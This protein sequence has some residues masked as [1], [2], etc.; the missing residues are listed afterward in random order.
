M[1]APLLP[2]PCNVL[3]RRTLLGLLQDPQRHPQL[4]D[5]PLL[6]HTSDQHS[7]AYQPYR[8]APLANAQA[9]FIVPAYGFLDADELASIAVL[10]PVRGHRRIRSNDVMIDVL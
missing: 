3:R 4:R 1:P 2:L 7:V 9:K 6:T 5:L 10:P 8:A